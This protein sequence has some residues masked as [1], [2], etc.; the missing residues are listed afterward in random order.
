M[1]RGFYQV[2]EGLRAIPVGGVFGAEEVVGLHQFD[3]RRNE[4]PLGG[5]Q[6]L[7]KS[8]ADFPQFRHGPGKLA[9]RFG[10]GLKPE[11]RRGLM[12]IDDL[13]VRGEEAAH[14]ETYDADVF[15]EFIWID[16]TR[17]T[18][19]T[20][21][22][23][24][25]KYRFGVLRRI[26]ELGAEIAIHPTYAREF[27]IGDCLMFATHA[28]KRIGREA[29]DSVEAARRGSRALASEMGNLGYDRLSAENPRVIFVFHRDQIFFSGL[30]PGLDMPR[31]TRL[32]PV[33]V[34]VPEIN[35]PFAVIMPGA[36]LPFR[37][38]PPD[39][40]AQVA[41]ALF[42]THGLRIVILGSATDRLK[43]E[44]M[45][46]AAPEI[47]M[48][49]LCGT[50]SL[51]QMIYLM[52]RC[53]LG[54]TNESGGAHVLAALDRPGVTV[55]TGNQFGWFFPY[56]REISTSVSYVYPPDFYAQALSWD[57]RVE[58]YRGSKYSLEGVLAE[59]VIERATAVLHGLPFHDPL[60]PELVKPASKTVRGDE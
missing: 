10:I 29:Y 23:R 39:R 44:A 16:K 11:C 2:M 53:V 14:I 41:R 56:P 21:L 3:A 42:L 5:R 51:P 24:Q 4:V 12:D 40:F 22:I 28:A 26:K 60:Q 7:R 17:L 31:H 27:Y 25:M 1:A 43:G 34:A 15:D 47:A 33:P 37:E 36:N 18:D 13:V 46:Q 19:Q 8:R 9:A 58:L 20:K 59:A 50:L 48:E 54:I 45:Q 52:S 57:E 30:L 6:G 32:T 49:N 55:S 35:G 38:W